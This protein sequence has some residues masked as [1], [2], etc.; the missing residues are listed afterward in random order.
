MLQTG[1]E[2]APGTTEDCKK[3]VGQLFPA[4]SLL[5]AYRTAREACKTSDIVLVASDQ[6]ED[7]NGGSRM[8]YCKHLKKAFGSRATAFK[9]W[10]KSAHSEMKLPAESEAMWLVLDIRSAALPSM[11]VIYATPYETTAVSSLD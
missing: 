5:S 8:E 10:H 2:F 9:L 6:S 3:I 11:C 7:I 4:A 1:L